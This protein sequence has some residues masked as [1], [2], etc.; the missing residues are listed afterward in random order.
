MGSLVEDAGR[1]A[2]WISTALNS[3]GYRADFSI[4][5][6]REIDRFFDEHS[7]QGRPVPGGLLSEDLGSRIFSLGSYVGEVIR[8][9]HGG[10]WRGDDSDPEGE[11][12]IELVLPNGTI[13]WPVQRAMKRFK[14]GPEE[15][16]YVYGVAVG[17][18]DV[19][20]EFRSPPPP[21]PQAPM[22]VR[23]KPW[24]RLG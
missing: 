12:K 21:A 23:K 13:M 5:S 2:E 16:I 14:K 8:R 3:S 9:T 10:S 11:I 4:D 6:L 7:H 15:S 18:S 17:G 24:W 22:T 20:R 1:A 19:T